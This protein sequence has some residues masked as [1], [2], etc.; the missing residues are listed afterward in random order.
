VRPIPL[1]I[2]ALL[3]GVTPLFAQ[4]AQCAPYQSN[5]QGYN[6]CNAAIDGTVLF[7]PV[8]GMLVS[9]GNPEIGT[10][11]T[12][13]GLP[14]FSITLRVNGSQ[15]VPPSLSY[16]GSST[17]VPAGNQLFAPLPQVDAAVGLFG[18]L[19]SGL[20]AIDALI[21]AQLL[22]TNQFQN[23][24]LDPNATRIGEV[25]LGLGFGGRVGVLHGGG[26]IPAVSVSAMYRNIPTITYGNVAA[27]DQF[28]YSVDLHAV[29]LRA[30]GGYN[31]G[32]VSV[33][34]GLGWNSYTGSANTS[35]RDPLTNTVQPPIAISL[36]QKR[37]M[38]FGDAALNMGVVK[39]AAEAGWQFGKSEQFATTFEQNNPSDSRFFANFGLRFGF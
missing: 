30:M 8:V 22:P 18:G 33:A 1:T 16:D 13:G 19:P 39:L 7:H 27:G 29:N 20:L 11:R 14:H 31:L 24:T 6:V 36:D 2:A 15:V 9:G 34:A 23:V 3:L 26:P 28:Q 25:G 12:L 10:A 21:S 32:L 35:F 4:N 17:T 5:A 38:A 37:T